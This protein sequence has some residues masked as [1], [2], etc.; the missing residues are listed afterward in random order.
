M[1]GPGWTCRPICCSAEPRLPRRLN[2]YSGDF[3][4]GERWCG[5]CMGKGASGGGDAPDLGIP[6][7]EQTTAIVINA[8]VGWR[9]TNAIF[10]C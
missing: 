10:S 6:Y 3:K 8:R 9:E 5:R 7:L 1:S 4:V 2:F